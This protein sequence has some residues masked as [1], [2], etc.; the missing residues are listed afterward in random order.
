MRKIAIG[1]LTVVVAAALFFV[2]CTYRVR[3]YE[4][5][6]LNRFGK[7]VGESGQARIAFGWYLCWPT[8][9]VVRLDKRLHL[10][11]G[12]L[13]QMATGSK[14]TLSVRAFA[15]WRIKYPVVFYQSFQGNDAKAD[16]MIK[17]KMAGKV[18][19]VVGAYPLSAL[20][21]AEKG[22]ATS[23]PLE[24]G[25][26]VSETA[27]QEME[28]KVTQRVNE[29]LKGLGIEVAEVGF[30][31]VA[32]P[33]GVAESVYGRMRQ[34]RDTLAGG[35]QAEGEAEATKLMAEARSQAEEK[36]SAAKR[37]A[38]NIR[39]TGDALAIQAL[40]SV[41]DTPEKKEFYQFWREMELL[42]NAIGKGTYF[43]LRGDQP[44]DQQLWWPGR[45]KSATSQPAR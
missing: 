20:F 3:P 29:E 35:F 39:G 45:T 18:A 22:S 21:G 34:E 4:S 16:S 37:E 33:P 40:A 26:K 12:A 15:A 5:V 43:I 6:I 14:E 31:R 17:E 11:Q 27:T 8:D 24:G 44:V 30:S 19:E 32:F 38:E 10:H 9:V 25:A 13:M 41:Q 2:L 23:M 28:G 36:R 1:L 7:A 42:K